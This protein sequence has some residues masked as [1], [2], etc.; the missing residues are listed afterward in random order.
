MFNAIKLI[1]LKEIKEVRRDRRSLMVVL[2]LSILMPLSFLGSMH[3]ISMKNGE[4]EAFE[5]S[6]VGSEHD[7]ALISFLNSKGFLT[8]AELKD[9]NVQLVIPDD[10]QQLLSK[11]FVP[12][13]TIRV[14]YSKFPK[15]VG[16]LEDALRDYNRT[17][18]AGRL[19]ERGISPVIMQPFRVDVVDTGEVSMITR[20]MAPSLIF[21][22]LI[23]PIYVLMPA[24]IDCTAGE[25]ERHGLFPL[26]LQPIP[27]ISITVGKYLML[28]A[29]GMA[30]LALSVL[31][32][33][34]GYSNFSPASMPFSFDMSLTN[35]LLFLLV[36]LPTV[37]VL[38]GLT[39][40]FASFAKTFKEGQSYVG[41]ASLVPMVFMVIGFFVDETWQPH[42]PFWSE[43]KILSALLSGES[44]VLMPWLISV[45]GYLVV[46]SLSLWWMSRTMQRQ[47][48]QSQ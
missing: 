45:A 48:I 33:F 32:G 47:A 41:M 3:F 23:V 42:L 21:M 12:S 37:M 19:V 22:F 26:L 28:V 2:F 18:V 25:R 44:I 46:I 7:P 10:Y 14:D 16:L 43:L 11:G 20:Y 29:S 38:A 31:V 8:T 36:A 9:S 15:A 35:G 40:G 4:A 30:G 6:I 39:M 5:Y 13:L 34:I 24:A 27:A 17:L 1:F